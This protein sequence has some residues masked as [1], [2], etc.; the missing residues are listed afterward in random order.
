MKQLEKHINFLSK[1]QISIAEL[2][3]NNQLKENSDLL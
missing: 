1:N 2:M 3:H